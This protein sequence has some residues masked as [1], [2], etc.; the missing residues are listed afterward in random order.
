MGLSRLEVNLRRLLV[1]CELLL[2]NKEQKDFPKYLS[3]LDDMLRDLKQTADSDNIPDYIRRIEALKKVI[4]VEHNASNFLN[5]QDDAELNSGSSNDVSPSKN[6]SSREQLLGDSSKLRLRSG[7]GN[8]DLDEAL[9][10]HQNMQQKI[11]DDM[12][13]L[14]R[15]LK[16]QSQLANKIIKRDTEVAANSSN[17]T[18]KN[19]SKLKVESEK[20]AE[21]SKRACKCWM[22]VM[23]IIVMVL[24]INMVLFMKVMKKKL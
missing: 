1:K 8:D 21:H 19:F 10:Y 4:I 6:L 22:W 16:E 24:F 14:T 13:T 23:L 11:A 12:L 20:L 5:A 17:L 9:E 3:S 15:N 7:K 18:E 2:K